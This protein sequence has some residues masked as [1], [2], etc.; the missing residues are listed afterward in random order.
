MTTYKIPIS[1]LVVIH[2]SDL[3]VLMLERASHPGFWQS[4]TG[5][6]DAEDEPLMQTAIREVG[7]ETGLDATA[8]H[9]ILRDWK[10]SASY[11]IYYEWKHRFAPGVEQNL[12]HVF[13]LEIP[14]PVMVTLSPREHI[15]QMWLPYPEAAAKVFSPTNRDAILALP[16]HIKQS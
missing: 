4:V 13:S 2:T 6:L 16:Q 12:E 11:D 10:Q 3:Q 1:V 5:S 7:E 14:A 8:P 9:H 15:S